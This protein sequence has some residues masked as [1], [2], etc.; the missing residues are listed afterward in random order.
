MAFGNQQ[1]V[2]LQLS[3]SPWQVSLLEAQ[4]PPD[5]IFWYESLSIDLIWDWRKL[6]LRIKQRYASA[7]AMQRRQPLNEVQTYGGVWPINKR[8]AVD[9]DMHIEV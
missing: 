6:A 8:A 1:Y 9:R 3:S 7:C 2:G 5:P 4:P